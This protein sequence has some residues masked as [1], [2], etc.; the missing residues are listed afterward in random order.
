MLHSDSRHQETSLCSAA[1]LEQ[2][3]SL[4]GL[5]ARKPLLAMGLSYLPK[6][7]SW[8][9]SITIMFIHGQCMQSMCGFQWFA[10]S[11]FT[12]HEFQELALANWNQC[13]SN[14]KFAAWMAGRVGFQV[15]IQLYIRGYPWILQS[16]IQPSPTCHINKQESLSMCVTS[17]KENLW[18]SGT[19]YTATHEFH[20]LSTTWNRTWNRW[21]VDGLD[22]TWTVVQAVPAPHLLTPLVRKVQGAEKF[23][24]VQPAILKKIFPNGSNRFKWCLK[25]PLVN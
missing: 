24:L 25:Y 7:W 20:S 3:T 5:H 8:K 10:V 21:N 17:N 13:A 2:Q 15:K 19:V 1:L 9:G 4:K 11:C 18:K 23:S 12:F 16:T 14:K 22:V 6:I